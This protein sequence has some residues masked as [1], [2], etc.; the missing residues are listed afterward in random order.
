MLASIFT[1]TTTRKIATA[2]CK[3][4]PVNLRETQAAT[5]SPSCSLHNQNIRL[6]FPLIFFQPHQL[7][8]RLINPLVSIEL[9]HRSAIMSNLAALTKSSKYVGIDNTPTN[10]HELRIEYPILDLLPPEQ[11]VR[12]SLSQP[13]DMSFREKPDASR[14]HLPLTGTNF[15]AHLSPGDRWSSISDVGL[16]P[17]SAALRQT[18]QC[19]RTE[20]TTDCHVLKSGQRRDVSLAAVR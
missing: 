15:V 18:S 8:P 5:K 13:T 3:G 19:S 4:H 16:K 10:Y 9:L 1:D 17:I 11:N 14:F 12:P 7:Q 6:C 2:L 20:P